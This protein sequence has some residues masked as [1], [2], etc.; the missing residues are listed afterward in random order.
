MKTKT[1]AHVMC[2]CGKRAFEDE[3]MAEKALGRAVTKHNRAFDQGQ[4]RR[5]MN[6]E[7][8]AY[9]CDTSGLFHLTS[10]SRR[11]FQSRALPVAPVLT[12][13]NWLATA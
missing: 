10:E 9:V 12:W 7:N 8:R 13:E 2:L 1:V 11:S 6:R 4:S 3:R 5:G